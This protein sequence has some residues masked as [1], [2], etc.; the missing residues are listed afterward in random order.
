[1]ILKNIPTEYYRS[2]SLKK[3][4]KV[5]NIRSTIQ[6]LWLSSLLWQRVYRSPSTGFESTGHNCPSFVRLKHLSN[7]YLELGQDFFFQ[8]WQFFFYF[9]LFKKLFLKK[10]PKNSSYLFSLI[11]TAQCLRSKQRNE[12]FSAISCGTCILRHELSSHT[13][14]LNFPLL[15]TNA[16]THIRF[17]LYW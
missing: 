2:I 10:T 4:T 6:V 13:T 11:C 9:L 12:F 16:F 1:M 8:W 5:S 17:G 14:S 15:F 7:T 3:N